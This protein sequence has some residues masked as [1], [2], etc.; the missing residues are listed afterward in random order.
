MMVD[1]LVVMSKTIWLVISIILGILVF[2]TIVETA[3][4]RL[5]RRKGE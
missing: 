1:L 2:A 4:D 3:L 5:K